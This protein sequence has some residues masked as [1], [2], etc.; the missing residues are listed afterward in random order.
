VNRLRAGAPVTLGSVRIIPLER[1]RVEGAAGKRGLFLY[2]SKTPVGLV[3]STQDQ[4]CAVD[5]QGNPMPLDAIL[6][7]VNGSGEGDLAPRRLP[8]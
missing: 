8:S 5:L 1:V 3:I 6:K 2:A 7:E 4:D